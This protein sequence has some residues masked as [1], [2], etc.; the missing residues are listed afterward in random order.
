[1]PASDDY[2]AWADH[3]RDNAGVNVIPADSRKK[4]P[5]VQWAQYQDKP[6]PKEVHTKWKS[7]NGFSKGLAVVLGKI[8]H[9]KDRLEYVLC[10]VDGDNSLAIKEFCGNKTLPDRANE[11]LVEQHKDDPNRAHFHFYSLRQL[12]KRLVAAVRQR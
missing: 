1:M 4:M 11:T 10:C 5:L 9:R 6:I 8:W 7:E 3:W 12:L 2:N